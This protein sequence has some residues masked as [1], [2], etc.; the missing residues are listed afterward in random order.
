MTP[1][2]GYA[3]RTDEAHH[4]RMGLLFR[5]SKKLGKGLRLNL[6]Q[7]GVSASARRG[8]LSVSSKG[9]VSVRLG[10]GFSWRIW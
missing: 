9:R 2:W 5:R 10:K 1:D 4:C 8:P 3:L 7:R 6:T